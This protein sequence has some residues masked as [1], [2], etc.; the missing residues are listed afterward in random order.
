MPLLMSLL[1]ACDVMSGVI[2]EEIP[3]IS[4]FNF[5]TPAATG[6]INKRARTITI[7][8]WGA[9]TTLVPSI[10]HTGV[11][12][13]PVSGVA[14]NFTNPVTYTVTAADGT[15]QAYIVTVIVKEYSLKEAGPAGGTIFYINGSPTTWK[16]LEAAPSGWNS[17]SDPQEFWEPGP[18]ALSGTATA[19]GTGYDN[20]YNRLN[21]DEHPAAKICRDYRGGGI[22][23]WFL[24]SID[25]LN[26]LRIQLGSTAGDRT[27]YG[28]IDSGYWSSY[29]HAILDARG[30]NFLNGTTYPYSKITTKF[31]RPIRA[32]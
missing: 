26:Q 27:T 4:T 11:N 16:Y 7:T 21:G 19:I 17:G 3:F 8:V 22:E 2:D 28:F 14:Q 6:V 23:G 24:P 31:V 10:T 13:S 29:D 20:T 9:V 18:T 15:T 32:F 25:E 12:I 5:T 1:L 30:I